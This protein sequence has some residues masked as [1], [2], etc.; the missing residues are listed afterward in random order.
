[1]ISGMNEKE[2][3]IP[4]RLQMPKGAISHHIG[5]VQNEPT[6]SPLYGPNL[7]SDVC[8]EISLIRPEC[9]HL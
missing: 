3:N 6:P 9:R 5:P 4:D 7:P 1:M 2:N 8:C